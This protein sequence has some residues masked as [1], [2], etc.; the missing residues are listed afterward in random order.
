VDRL[1]PLC[2]PRHLQPLRRR[3]D[4]CPA[5][6]GS[7]RHAP[8]RRDQR[9]AG[10]RGGPP[11]LRGPV[12][13]PQVRPG[14]FRPVRQLRGRPRLLP[15]VL[16]LLQPRA[17]ALG[18]R[19]HDPIDRPLRA[20]APNRRGASD[21]AAAAYASHPE[22]FVR[23]PPRPPILPEA[24]WINP[25]AKNPTHQ[26]APGSMILTRA[27]IWVPPD[28]VVPVLSHTEPALIAVPAGRQEVAH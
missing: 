14:V 20:R 10:H 9:Q 5:G 12:Q 3:L 7:V 16:W 11:L 27:E 17:P 21:H 4:A 25:P 23:Q 13:D 15:S 1:L 18:H 8:D 2:D 22:R 26:D 28:S 19:A 6:D 24:A